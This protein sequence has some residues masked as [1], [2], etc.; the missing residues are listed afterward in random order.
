[1]MK[2]VIVRSVIVALLAM[3]SMPM[4]SAQT[5]P[6]A[7]PAAK[8]A[9]A[10]PADQKASAKIDPIDINSASKEELMTLAGIGEAYAGKIIAGR[11]YKTKTDLKTKKIVPEATYEKISEKIIAKQAA[12]K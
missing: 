1:M 11:P 9:P 8:A 7:K 6:A 5:K 2:R 3:A 4:L 10:K 12:K